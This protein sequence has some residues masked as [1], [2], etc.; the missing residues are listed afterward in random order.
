MKTTDSIRSYSGSY[1]STL[2]DC[3]YAK[4]ESSEITLRKYEKIQDEFKKQIQDLKIQER[5]SLSLLDKRSQTLLTENEKMKFQISNFPKKS[6]VNEQIDIIEKYLESK[7]YENDPERPLRFM[8]KLIITKIIRK[9][10][11]FEEIEARVNAMYN[12]VVEMKKIN[13]FGNLVDGEETE[14]A[15]KRKIILMKDNGIKLASNQRTM[16]DIRFNISQL[17]RMISIE[18]SKKK[19]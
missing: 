5:K 4:L 16:N 12:K 3:E 11:E 7:V 6:F 8:E 14:E 15:L 2:A 18:K 9:E 13:D 1:A 19:K 17:E 10:E